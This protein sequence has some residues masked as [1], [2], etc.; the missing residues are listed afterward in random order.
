MVC[1]RSSS[2]AAGKNEVVD[3]PKNKPPTKMKTCL[4][5]HKKQKQQRQ[6]HQENEEGPLVT[7]PT[8]MSDT[9]SLSL[10]LRLMTPFVFL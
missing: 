1:T 8:G 6:L 3:S 5:R 9:H 7:P 10:S 2:Q 4:K